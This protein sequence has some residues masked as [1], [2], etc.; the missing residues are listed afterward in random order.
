MALAW[1]WPALPPCVT[2]R[3]VFYGALDSHPFFRMLRRV[4]AFCRPLQPVLLLVGVVSA[5]LP[6]PPPP[7]VHVMAKSNY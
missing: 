7:V 3:L 1:A 4:A 6:P 5:F 2:F